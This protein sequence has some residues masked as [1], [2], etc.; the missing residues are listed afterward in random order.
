MSKGTYINHSDEGN[1][2][3]R[4]LLSVRNKEGLIGVAFLELG[5]NK[6]NMGSIKDDDNF[7]TYKMLINQI[8]P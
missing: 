7:T 6:I 1:Y 4:Y 5:T 8:R 3:P 2:E